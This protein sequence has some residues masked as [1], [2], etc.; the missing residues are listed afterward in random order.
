MYSQLPNKLHIHGSDIYIS[1]GVK[2][3][4]RK[5]ITLVILKMVLGLINNIDTAQTVSTLTLIEI[6]SQHESYEYADYYRNVWCRCI[7]FNVDW[8]K[9]TQFKNF[10]NLGGRHCYCWYNNQCNQGNCGGFLSTVLLNKSSHCIQ[11]GG[12]TVDIFIPATTGY[13]NWKGK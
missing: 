6:L 12:F 5:Q 3:G 8:Y 10:S 2:M 1:I 11:D 9:Y 4:L 13:R 7:V